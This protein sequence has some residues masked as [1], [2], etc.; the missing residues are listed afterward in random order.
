MRGFPLELI[1]QDLS[2]LA[3]ACVE[4]AARLA[5]SRA[6]AR[7]GVPLTSSGSTARFVVLGLGKLGGQ[8]LNYSSDIDLIFLYDEDGQTDWSQ[9]AVQRRDVRQDRQRDRPLAVR[10]HGHWA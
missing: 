10:S 9:G 6:E 4:V 8:E 5:R 1:T 7:F 2:D 3:D